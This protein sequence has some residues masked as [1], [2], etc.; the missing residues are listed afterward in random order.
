MLHAV[1]GDS[2]G[3]VCCVWIV[4][5]L[6]ICCVFGYVVVGYFDFGYVEWLTC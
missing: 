2:E 5:V 6:W 1:F 4:C 3:G